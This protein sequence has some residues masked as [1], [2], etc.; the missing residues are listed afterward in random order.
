LQAHSAV[1]HEVNRSGII[2]V[3][4]AVFIGLFSIV[5]GLIGGTILGAKAILKEQPVTEE[6]GDNS[7]PTQWATEWAHGD[8]TQADY[9]FLMKGRADGCK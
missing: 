6:C 1:R 8:I 4:A 7:L 3:I 9:D 2:G 5:A